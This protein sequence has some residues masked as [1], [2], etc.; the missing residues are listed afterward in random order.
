MQCICPKCGRKNEISI[1]ELKTQHGNVVCP[2]CLTVTKVE[3]PAI[4]LEEENTTPPDI[5][6]KK[7]K[8]S[9][10]VKLSL[11]AMTPP[12]VQYCRHCG[13]R[14]PAGETSCPKCG[15]PIVG[16][17]GRSLSRSTVNQQQ[18]RRP[19]SFAESQ[20][21]YSSPKNTG[22]TRRKQTVHKKK[23]K[24][25]FWNYWSNKTRTW[26]CVGYTVLAATVF[27]LLYYL[28]GSLF[29]S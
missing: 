10:P 2:R 17:K 5:P 14:I 1:A 8:A 29:N 24:Q 20:S 19:I 27:F 4:P 13:N 18:R 26:G 23:Q 22:R 6:E 7:R 16:S 25:G 11:R 15:T 3:I 12:P 28:I 9:T 21:N